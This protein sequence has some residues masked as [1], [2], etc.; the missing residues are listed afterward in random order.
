MEH[1]KNLTPKGFTWGVI[2]FGLLLAF[3]AFIIFA[4]LIILVRYLFYA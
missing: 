1:N 4:P 2:K 3:L